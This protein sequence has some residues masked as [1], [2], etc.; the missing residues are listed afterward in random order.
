MS[1]VPY[2]TKPEKKTSLVEAV[3]SKIPFNG[4]PEQEVELRK[5][6]AAHKDQKG[7]LMPILQQ[8]Q[9]IY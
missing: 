8:A 2:S 9:E 7:A 1:I 5:L 4:T 3:K 6:I